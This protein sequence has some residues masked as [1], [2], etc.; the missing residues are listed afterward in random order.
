MRITYVEEARAV[1][2]ASEPVTSLVWTL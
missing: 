2:Q 1:A